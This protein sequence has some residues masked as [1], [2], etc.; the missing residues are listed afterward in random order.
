MA[1][2][3]GGSQRGW[4]CFSRAEH[5]AKLLL[6]GGR[7]LTV[8]VS[9][10]PLLICVCWRLGGLSPCLETTNVTIAMRMRLESGA[11]ES[12]TA[13]PAAPAP[14][15]PTNPIGESPQ[16]QSISGANALLH[17][18]T[19]SARQVHSYSTL[20]SSAAFKA[21]RTGTEQSRCLGHRVLLHPQHWSS[22]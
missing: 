10:S 4:A 19:L 13:A 5:D 20:N 9:A 2:A 12:W 7:A 21:H 3:A 11:L 16:I 14:A 17:V 22:E 18:H 1:P 15:L 8:Q 6:K